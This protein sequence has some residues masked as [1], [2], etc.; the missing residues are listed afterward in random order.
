MSQAA[1]AKSRR[2]A[3]YGI[4]VVAALTAGASGTFAAD[5]C[6]T[7]ASEI[8]TDRPDVTN[9]S[10]V[11]PYGSLQAENGVDWT[12][13]HG[14]NALDATNTRLRLGVA[15]CTEFVVDIP[16]YFDSLNGSQP[17]GFSD[18]VVS[19]KRQLAVPFGF[20]LSVTGGAAFPS[21]S[22]K[23]SGR[24]YQPLVQFPWSHLLAPDWEVAGMFTLFWSPSESEHNLTF[25]PTLSLER[26]FGSAADLFVEYVGQYDHQRPAHLLDGGGSWRVTRLQQLDF[27]VGFGLNR[28]SAALNGVPVDQFFGIGYSI[29]LDGLFGGSV[30]SS[31]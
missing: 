8:S 29:R 1:L 22:S 4:L 12:V 31:P 24:G 10:L 13:R 9:S 6:P 28:S 18:I 3:I 2:S 15:H 30:G 19:F 11:V 14:S 17:R 20:D 7:S 23:I 26:E 25:Q 5:G 16:S 27:H 21:G